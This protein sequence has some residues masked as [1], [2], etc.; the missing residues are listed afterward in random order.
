M[1]RQIG[2][3]A[4]LAAILAAAGGCTQEPYAT[5]LPDKVAVATGELAG[6]KWQLVEFQS[7]DDAVATK[8]P[9]DPSRYTMELAGNGDAAFQLD[10]N[11]GMGSYESQPSS[12]GYGGSLTFSVLATTK[13]LCPPPTMGESL[14]RDVA[15][16]RSYVLEGDRL[17]VAL[18]A[19]GGIY[20]WERIAE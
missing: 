9:S 16:M 19:D 11:R 4:L 7:M 10:C 18:M 20:V 6:T 3:A 17:H 14:A 2:G 12:G 1:I 5:Q 15:Y 13:A 8:R